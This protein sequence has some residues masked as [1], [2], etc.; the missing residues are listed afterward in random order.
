MNIALI[1]AAGSSQR[2]HADKLKQFYQIDGRPLI[3]YAIKSFHA[4]KEID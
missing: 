3:W 4:V 2:F 1:L